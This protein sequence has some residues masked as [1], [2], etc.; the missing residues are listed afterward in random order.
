L[1][2]DMR[3]SAVYRSHRKHGGEIAK[4]IGRLVTSVKTSERRASRRQVSATLRSAL[5]YDLANI[6][7]WASIGMPAHDLTESV[8]VAD[9]PS[10]AACVLAGYLCDLGNDQ[11]GHRYIFVREDSL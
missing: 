11:E 6:E 9:M 2:N 7:T 8:P 5:G 3:L 1:K 10:S 4:R